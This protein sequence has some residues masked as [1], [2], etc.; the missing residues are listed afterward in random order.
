MDRKNVQPVEEV[1]AKCSVGP[2]RDDELGYRV[3]DGS[4]FLDDQ[5]KALLALLERR[6]V[7]LGTS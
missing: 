2:N 6:L 5:T 3:D 7:G 4:K 1:G